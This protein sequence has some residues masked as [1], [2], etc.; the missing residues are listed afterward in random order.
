MG[1]ADNWHP[2]LADAL[3]LC[4]LH[5]ALKAYDALQASA[6]QIRCAE[7]VLTGKGVAEAV[8]RY[9]LLRQQLMRRACCLSLSSFT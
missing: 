7:F 8:R 3:L 4:Q 9:N 5:D 6:Q 2:L 1:F